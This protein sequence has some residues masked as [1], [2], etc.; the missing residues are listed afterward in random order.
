MLMLTAAVKRHKQRPQR[1]TL[2]GTSLAP[3]SAALLTQSKMAAG[4][5]V[6]KSH[7][8][9]CVSDNALYANGLLTSTFERQKVGG[10]SFQS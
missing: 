2:V 10:D 3:S 4:D 6:I 1:N 9:G 5:D 7:L 8:P